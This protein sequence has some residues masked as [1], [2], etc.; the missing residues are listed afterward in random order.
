VTPEWWARMEALFLQALDCSP[1]ER[2]ALLDRECGGDEAL[3]HEVEAML[4][5]NER[6]GSFL[7]VP[8][9]ARTS[10]MDAPVVTG[11]DD[12]AETAHFEA[13]A[14][15]RRCERCGGR[16]GEDH[17][18]CP[19]DGSPL[20]EDFEALL[21]ATLDGLYRI[22]ALLGRGGMGAVYRARHVLLQDTVAIKVLPREFGHNPRWL[23]RFFREG[24]AARLFQ[25]SSAVTVYDLRMT[26]DATVYLVLECV[27][28]ETLRVT[29][30]RGRFGAAEAL[31]VLAPV[32]GCLDEAH[33]AGVVHRDVKP[34]NVMLGGFG[35]GAAVTV[36]LLDLGIAKLFAADRGETSTQLTTPGA[37]LGTPRYMS[38]EQ[39]GEPLRDG[40]QEIDGRA[41]VYSLAVV[42][43]EMVVGEP[44][45]AGKSW[46]ELR[47][48]HTSETPPPAH[49]RV[50]ELPAA[51]GLAV[52]RAM[53]KDRAD[54]FATAGEFVR[55]LRQALAPHGGEIETAP[56]SVE[57]GAAV[58]QTA[59]NPPTNLPEPFTTFVGRE[60]EVADVVRLLGPARLVTITG[61]G[62]I[63]KTRLAIRAAS[64]ALGRFP[65][66]VWLVDLAPLSDPTF[67]ELAVASAVGARQQSSA[68]L[69]DVVCEYA[70][71]RRF[72]LVLDNCEHLLEACS[73]V[74]ARLLRSCP[75]VGILATSREEL[76]LQSEVVWQA[77]PLDT[78]DTERLFVE[79][80]V[81]AHRDFAVTPRN[82]ASI[83]ELCRQLEGLPL[84]VELAAAR[85]RVLT[86]A[87]MLERLGQRLDLLATRSSEALGR[88]RTLRASIEW[89]YELLAREERRVFEALSVFRGG[90]RL[91]AAEAVTRGQ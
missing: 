51:Y 7:E 30:G 69:L 22:E 44:P 26:E 13:V 24:H 90:W 11:A 28:G 85:M 34:E 41:D 5:T 48:Q 3:R 25:H 36:K 77:P 89:S 80:A 27:E 83:E 56:Q 53:S 47:R 17:V 39:W 64:E 42:A 52:A 12:N 73:A 49:E 71:E 74:A 29:M 40:G 61:P 14:R 66:G 81:L 45:F 31:G 6:L 91:E 10:H 2:G 60:R 23:Q 87:Q 19:E 4:A 62:G 63:G 16:Y 50:P 20:V 33:R 57:T 54:R 58:P 18:F 55:T 78:R 38:P 72:L 35:G 59:A 8:A 84:A 37:A 68:S 75:N 46:N 1:R 32:A 86:P 76:R 70:R 82:A 9:G 21:G 79:R 15:G 43:Y 67:V 88:H 65:D